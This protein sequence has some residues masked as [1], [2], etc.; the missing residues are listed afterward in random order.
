MRILLMSVLTC[1]V[2]LAV[3]ISLAGQH[4]RRQLRRPMET[5]PTRLRSIKSRSTRLAACYRETDDREQSSSCHRDPNRRRKK[6]KQIAGLPRDSRPLVLTWERIYALAL[7]RARSSRD[8]F[9][10]TLDPTALEQEAARQASPTLIGSAAISWVLSPV[11]ATGF[12]IPARRFEALERARDNRQRGPEHRSPRE[13]L[14]VS[15]GADSGRVIGPAATR[16]RHGVR[17]ARPG[18]PEA[19]RRDQSIP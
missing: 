14:Q 12:A 10:E 7:V 19:C 6:T 1:A 11:P 2:V 16:S 9:A 8:A 13:H 4:S 18:P 5:G 15:H 3:Q 17:L